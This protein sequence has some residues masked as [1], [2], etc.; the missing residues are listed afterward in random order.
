MSLIS[1]C[2][3]ERV[4]SA[5]KAKRDAVGIYDLYSGKRV[6]EVPAAYPGTIYIIFRCATY[7]LGYVST[8][9]VAGLTDLND[10]EELPSTQPA[11]EIKIDATRINRIIEGCSASIISQYENLMVNNRAFLSI[12]SYAQNCFDA[13]LDCA[14]KD[15]Y[16]SELISKGKISR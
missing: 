12:N 1:G 13:I 4:S 9:F 15:S 7:V 14:S 11:P 8:D 5:V 16:I 3:R 10:W 6:A 2:Q